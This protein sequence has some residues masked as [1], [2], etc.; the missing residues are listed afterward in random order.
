MFWNEGFPDITKF[1]LY[2]DKIEHSFV[3]M[4]SIKKLKVKYLSRNNIKDFC[5]NKFKSDIGIKGVDES[6]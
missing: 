5:D 3:K 6:K 1:Y 2:L 4:I